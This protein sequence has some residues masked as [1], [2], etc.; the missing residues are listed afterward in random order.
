MSRISRKHF[1]MTEQLPKYQKITGFD[2]CD[3][4]I[5]FYL[6]PKQ[7]QEHLFYFFLATVGML[8]AEENTLCAI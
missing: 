4:D 8:C 6:I 1:I 7:E 3:I 2:L 5:K